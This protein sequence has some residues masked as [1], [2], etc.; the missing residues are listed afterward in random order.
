MSFGKHQEF[1][2]QR[3]FAAPPD[4][5]FEAW[6][7]PEYLDWFFN[8][9]NPTDAAISVDLRVGG[10]WRQEMVISPTHRYF[11]GGLYREI[12]PGRKLA[13]AWGAVGG[14]PELDLERPDDNPQ[15]TL[16]FSPRGTTTVLDLKVQ[17]VDDMA[18]DKVEYWMNCGMREGWDMT[19]DRLVARYDG[20]GG[21]R[22]AG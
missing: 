21:I 22:R 5:V 19:V 10:Q 3:V 4:V 6:T 2:M 9:D 20:R 13:F 11:T 8:P 14:W 15:V 18:D 1:S 17:F 16:G 7:K 12:E